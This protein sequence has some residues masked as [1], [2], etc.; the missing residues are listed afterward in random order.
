MPTHFNQHRKSYRYRHF[1][2]HT[3]SSFSLKLNSSTMRKWFPSVNFQHSG[4]PHCP[5]GHQCKNRSARFTLTPLKKTTENPRLPEEIPA[6][7]LLIRTPYMACIHRGHPVVVFTTVRPR[8]T[9]EQPNS[10]YIYILASI[11]L[12]PAPLHRHS[13]CIFSPDLA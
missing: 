10:H 7:K 3:L 2:S 9:R 6:C 11:L 4:P 13:F 8:R 1:A 5:H 12:L